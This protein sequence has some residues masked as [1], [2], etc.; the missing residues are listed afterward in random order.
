MWGRRVKNVDFDY[1]MCFNFYDY[2]SKQSR[3]RK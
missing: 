3:H 2:Q 1:R